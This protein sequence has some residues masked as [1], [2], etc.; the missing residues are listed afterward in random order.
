MKS[1][2]QSGVALVITLL[3]LSAITFLTVAFLAVSRRDRAAITVYMDQRDARGMADAALA[4]AESEIISRMMPTNLSTGNGPEWLNY[5]LMVS[6]NYINKDGFSTKSADYTN[7]YNVNY[8]HYLGKT[9]QNDSTRFLSTV[10]RVQNIA[11]LQYDARPPVF[12]KTNASTTYPLDFRFWIDFNRNGRFEDSG[13]LNETN[14]FGVQTT[15]VNLYEGEPQWIGVLQHPDAKHSA[16][17]WFIGRYAYLVQP[18]GK[19]LDWNFIHNH[20]TNLNDLRYDYYVRGSNDASWDINL[21]GFVQQLNTNIWSTIDVA[22][23]DSAFVIT[24]RV[25]DSRTKLNPFKLGFGY[26]ITNYQT[27]Y[28]PQM[29]F[30][31]T[32]SS[33]NFSSN[34]LLAGKFIT[35]TVTTTNVSSYNRYTFQRLL[36]SI[37]TDTEP[38]MRVDVSNG[39]DPTNGFRTKVNL[40]YNNTYEITHRLNSGTT[41]TLQTATN[42]IRWTPLAF[43]TNAADI[44]LRNEFTNQITVTDIPIYCSTNLAVSY[45]S[46][47]HRCLQLAANLYDATTPSNNLPSVFRPLYASAINQAKKVTNV[48]IMGYTEVTNDFVGT[49][50]PRG[51]KMLTSG[52][53][54]SNDNVIGIPFVIGVKKGYP[55]FNKCIITNQVTMTRKLAFYKSDPTSTDPPGY[56]NQTTLY[57]FKTTFG[58]Q[59]WNSYTNAFRKASLVVISNGVL[60]YVTNRHQVNGVWVK[61]ATKNYFQ[62]NLNGVTSYLPGWTLQSGASD[63]SSCS[64]IRQTNVQLFISSAQYSPWVQTN[65][66]FFRYIPNDARRFVPWNVSNVV[67][68]TVT[69]LD[70]EFVVTNR[71]MYAMVVSNRLVDFV[72]IEKASSIPFTEMLTNSG[73]RYENPWLMDT[74]FDNWPGVSNQIRLNLEGTA[75]KLPKTELWQYPSDTQSSKALTE[76]Q[77]W[78]K[79]GVEATNLNYMYAIFQ[80]NATVTNMVILQAN[81]PL[82]HYTLD[83]LLFSQAGKNIAPS[84]RTMSTR[85]EPWPSGVIEEGSTTTATK[86]NICFKDLGI[87]KSDDW[88]FPTNRFR[89]LG[90]IGRVHRG[91]PWETIYLKADPIYTAT[92]VSSAIRTNYNWVE[93]TNKWVNPLVVSNLVGSN[94]VYYI[95]TP[96]YPTNDWSIVDLFTVAP[97]N[98]ALR[99]TLSVNQTNEAAW[100]AVLTGIKLP[101]SAKVLSGDVPSI[102]DGY[103]SFTRTNCISSMR[104]TRPGHVFHR[105]G[106]VLSAQTLSLQSPYLSDYSGA[107]TNTDDMLEAIP[108]EML[109]LVRLGQPRFVIWAFGQSLKPALGSRYVVAGRNFNIC[110]NYQITGESLTRTVCHIEEDPKN[111]RIVV[112][113]FNVVP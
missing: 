29:L 12:I 42:H 44:L 48:W 96:N 69:G 79:G 108:R 38:E 28:D 77:Q 59:A 99:G 22:A 16:T 76:F 70:W 107:T 110:T 58:I 49:I 11:N 112:D 31:P 91:T 17:N 2:S 46:R 56:T 35:N 111:P 73:S 60:G 45:N 93:W 57:N 20:A 95:T 94:L 101:S 24:N 82:V 98:N 113:S 37:G 74:N 10:D 36:G 41:N 34:L 52:V 43:F 100:A 18:V 87:R 39:T 83:D 50:L 64:L 4:R 89:N 88:N 54:N 97:N 62:T 40:D 32:N 1:K 3:M 103:S 27:Y 15:N 80:P 105:M 109:S 23:Y 104:N 51:F 33:F 9:N 14:A 92:A 66:V 6:K 90:E 65:D 71:I 26:N 86:T 75:S 8:D 7:Y 78:W 67:H 85:Y 21:A 5:D 25:Y 55:N 81:D 47:I 102:V 30:E 13:Y 106:E 68:E 19:T 53:I 63:I 61:F 84:I 72:N